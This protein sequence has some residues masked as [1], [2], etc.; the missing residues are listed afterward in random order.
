MNAYYNQL[1]G[2]ISQTYHDPCVQS[3]MIYGTNTMFASMNTGSTRRDASAIDLEQRWSCHICKKIWN[4][5]WNNASTIITV[6]K[7]I[8]WT[9]TQIMLGFDERDAMPLNPT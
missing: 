7:M 6:V 9:D 2:W 3:A 8:V 5:F 1:V 4:F